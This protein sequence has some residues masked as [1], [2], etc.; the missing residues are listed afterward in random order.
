MNSEISLIKN[1]I[2]ARIRN[3]TPASHSALRLF[4]GF[5]EGFPDLQIDL[6]A[7]TILMMN[8]AKD[9]SNLKVLLPQLQATLI[10]TFPE[11]HCIVLKERYALQ[12]DNRNGRILLGSNPADWIQ[13]NNVKYYLDL[14]LNQDSSF[15]LDTRNL[16]IWLSSHAKGWEVLNT[17]AYTGSLGIACLAG[18]ASLVIQTDRTRRF[19]ELAE[20][21]L[22]LNNLPPKNHKIQPGDFFSI[23][24]RYRQKK[25]T[26]ECVIV[27]PPFFSTS[28][29]GTVDLRTQYQRIL[30]KVR[31]L[32]CDNGCLI[33]INNSLYQS[34]KD[35]LKMLE[36]IGSEGFVK[37]EEIIPVPE[38]VTGYPDTIKNFSPA[39]PAPFNHSTKIAI[40]KIR[41]K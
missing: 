39:D 36:E 2:Q 24:S 40:L 8:H 6:F 33:A 10:E 4:N 20:K 28:T 27:D 35:Y 7:D 11:I 9:P 17:F 16:R 5:L 34:G 13:E 23:A 1:A 25:G 41:R 14:T 21:S 15:Y 19:L 29:K 18:G 31:P 3:G 30:N 26:F 22:E 32:I 38:E 12:M 37:L